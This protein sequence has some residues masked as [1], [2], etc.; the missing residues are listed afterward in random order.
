MTDPFKGPIQNEYK[1]EIGIPHSNRKWNQFH[2]VICV[3]C[4]ALRTKRRQHQKQRRLMMVT[5]VNC[6]SGTNVMHKCLNYIH[7][8]QPYIAQGSHTGPWLFALCANFAF[9]HYQLY[10]LL[11]LLSILYS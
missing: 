6:K 8:A 1:P 10:T 4:A 2:A 7:I 9:L 5:I 11:F 3:R